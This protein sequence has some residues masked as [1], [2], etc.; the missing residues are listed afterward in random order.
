MISCR[1]QRDRDDDLFR[2]VAALAIAEAKTQTTLAALC[3]PSRK[4]IIVYLWLEKSIRPDCGA[5]IPKIPFDR[6]GS[7]DNQQRSE[8]NRST[9][10]LI[11]NLQTK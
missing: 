4:S 1:D 11:G 5:V 8:A 2:R 10:T 9:V 6:I 7:E 3:E